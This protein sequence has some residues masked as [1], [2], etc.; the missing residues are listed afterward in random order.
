MRDGAVPGSSAGLKVPLDVWWPSQLPSV[1][2]LSCPIACFE[3]KRV[4]VSLGLHLNPLKGV[5]AS[6]DHAY[7]TDQ[8][9]YGFQSSPVAG[10]HS[11]LIGS[12]FGSQ[13]G[14][15]FT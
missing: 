9:G 7:I 5:F 6:H 14:K 15:Q 8:T 12:S 11:L 10:P 13:R 3:E 1:L 2:G 4:A